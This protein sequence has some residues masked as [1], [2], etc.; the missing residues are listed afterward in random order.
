MSNEVTRSDNWN[1]EI[2]SNFSSESEHS[3]PGFNE[4]EST[5]NPEPMPES[6][7][8]AIAPIV[9]PAGG[10][11]ALQPEGV[12][13]AYRQ[14]D[15][16][17]E[18]PQE[19]VPGW[20]L[21]LGAV[22][23]ALGGWYFLQ[24]PPE[25]IYRPR[26]GIARF[27]PMAEALSKTRSQAIAPSAPAGWREVPVA[28]VGTTYVP[29]S[30]DRLKVDVGVPSQARLTDENSGQAGVVATSGVTS[31]AGAPLDGTR[32][33]YVNDVNFSNLLKNQV[34][35]GRY[36]WTGIWRGEGYDR[37]LEPAERLTAR[38]EGG[39]DI[40]L[41]VVVDTKI[42]DPSKPNLFVTVQSEQDENNQLTN[43][44]A[45]RYD[46]A[47]ATLERKDFGQLLPFYDVTVTRNGGFAGT[48]TKTLEPLGTTT[49]E[50]HV[51]P[52]DLASNFF[53]ELRGVNQF[54]NQR[55]M[56]IYELESQGWQV[57]EVPPPSAASDFD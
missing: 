41:K 54:Y 3:E 55:L 19:R 18:R 11:A 30:Q 44:S 35:P 39:A 29:S 13:Y 37:E 38:R 20:L 24:R 42:T 4:S 50:Y 36:E 48:E 7:P 16:V 43:L 14:F 2:E 5:F 53:L 33:P 45:F 49:F 9:T 15:G 10:A 26:I 31:A 8:Q 32:H 23:I 40:H 56:E 17:E 52:K 27:L 57:K 51:S 34:A 6:Q 25:A 28:G 1:P 22:A 47:G 12:D 46:A 21:G